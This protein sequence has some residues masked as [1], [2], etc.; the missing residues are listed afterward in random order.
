[1]PYLETASFPLLINPAGTA[2]DVANDLISAA[3]LLDIHD[4]PFLNWLGNNSTRIQYAIREAVGALTR[5]LGQDLRTLWQIA[6][7]SGFTIESR[8]PD[9]REPGQWLHRRSP[10]SVTE[11]WLGIGPENVYVVPANEELTIARGVRELV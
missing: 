2:A 5:P 4:L 9:S 3:K 10:K 7:D 11:A 6:D 1:M 8:S